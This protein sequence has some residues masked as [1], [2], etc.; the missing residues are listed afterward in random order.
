VIFYLDNLRAEFCHCDKLLNNHSCRYNSVNELNVWNLQPWL[1]RN[2]AL[3]IYKTPD[4]A[5]LK[6]TVGQVRLFNL[7][8]GLTWNMGSSVEASDGKGIG[9]KTNM[10]KEILPLSPSGRSFRCQPRLHWVSA[11]TAQR[12]AI[13]IDFGEINILGHCL[14]AIQI[15]PCRDK[16][17]IFW[18]GLTPWCYFRSQDREVNLPKAW[19][20]L[21]PVGEI[22]TMTNVP[23]KVQG[24]S[25]LVAPRIF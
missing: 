11:P 1:P 10:G 7:R 13:S 19:L 4:I 2:N 14:V 22:L 9:H 8:T 16:Y 3:F 18:D 12:N 17:I 5:R 23:H 24:I 25:D 20:N 21:R 6:K 15:C